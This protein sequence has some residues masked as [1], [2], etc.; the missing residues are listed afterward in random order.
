MQRL[1]MLWGRKQE[2]DSGKI[3]LT[4]EEVWQILLPYNTT[5]IYGQ[6][7]TKRL[8]VTREGLER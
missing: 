3:D 7:D 1:T 5:R 6:K 4:H 8:R 2:E